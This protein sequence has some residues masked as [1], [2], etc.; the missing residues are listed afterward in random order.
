MSLSRPTPF[1]L[2]FPTV[3]FRG[4]PSIFRDSF[5]SSCSNSNPDSKLYLPYLNSL[6]L[7]MMFL[8]ALRLVLFGYLLASGLSAE[9]SNAGSQLWDRAI[10]VHTFNQLDL[11]LGL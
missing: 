11:S 2:E 9:A 5:L 10:Q 8:F 6:G 4:I 3:E 7:D 1:E